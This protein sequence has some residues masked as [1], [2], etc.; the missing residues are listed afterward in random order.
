MRADLSKLAVWSKE[1][2]MFNVEKY[3]VMYQYLGYNNPKVNYVMDA[4]Q[5]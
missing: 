4:I 2:Q 1:R 3:K 5:L